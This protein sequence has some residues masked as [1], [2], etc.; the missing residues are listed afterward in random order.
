[1]G[2]RPFVKGINAFRIIK[3]LIVAIGILYTLV[4][5]CFYA[6]Y[7]FV[8][9]PQSAL[10][11][12]DNFFVRGSVERFLTPAISDAELINKFEAERE[13]L[14]R[15]VEIHT[16]GCLDDRLGRPLPEVKAIEGE[17]GLLE[18]F[19]VKSPLWLPDPY[20]SSAAVRRKERMVNMQNELDAIDHTLPDLQRAAA[21][22]RISEK[23][24]LERCKL[25]S[26]RF[27]FEKLPASLGLMKGVEYFPLPPMIKDGRM[28]LPSVT[29]SP[30]ETTSEEIVG[31]L[32]E[33]P[34]VGAQRECAYRQI[35]PQW[36]LSLCPD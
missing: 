14:E 7:A 33:L 15:I 23:Y 17:I 13:K 19:G 25:E 28:I 30:D 2:W 32:A 10:F 21:I 11:I 24:R 35:E 8:F 34:R 4:V 3:I 29:S 12:T 27:D 1:M 31:D 6:F 16:A 36:F 22:Q 9:D 26:I 20:S 18:V 5:I